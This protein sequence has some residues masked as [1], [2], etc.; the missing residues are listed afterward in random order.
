M[1]FMLQVTVRKPAD[2]TNAE[3]Y[4][5]W[6]EEA[7]TAMGAVRAGVIKSIYKVAGEPHVIAIVEVESHDQIDH[8]VQSLPIWKKGYAHLVE[9]ATWTPIRTYQSWHEQ[10]KELAKG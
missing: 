7:E 8:I 5:L 2:M 1:L 3:F 10:M 6:V 9:D 4:K